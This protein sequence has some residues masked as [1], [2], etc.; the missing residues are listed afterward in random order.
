VL[1][2]AA[3]GQ[4]NREIAARLH[5]TEDAVKWRFRKIFRA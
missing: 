2:L 1:Q 3:L 5:V 4:S